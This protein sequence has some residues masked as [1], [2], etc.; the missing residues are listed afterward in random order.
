MIIS[1]IA[2]VEGQGFA[3]GRLEKELRKLE[4][5]SR[6]YSFVSMKGAAE[7]DFG[8]V[9]IQVGIRLC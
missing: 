9:R 3:L 4:D 7:E 1:F 6:T 2:L 8:K 5:G